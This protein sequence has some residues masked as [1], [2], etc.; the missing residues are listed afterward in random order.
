MGKVTL[1]PPNNPIY[2]HFTKLLEKKKRRSIIIKVLHFSRK[3]YIYPIYIDFNTRR[4]KKKKRK[5]ISF[6]KLLEVLQRY[7]GIK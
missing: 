7:K 6:Q 2:W 4:D 1:I 5:F 3:V